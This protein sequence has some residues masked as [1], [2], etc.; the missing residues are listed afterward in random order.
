MRFQNVAIASVAYV[1]PTTVVRT[2]DLEAQLAPLYGRLGMRPGW[3]ETVTGI[4]ERRFW[5]PGV[6]PSQVAALAGRKALQSA[7][8]ATSQLGA[9][10]YTGVC[11]DYLEPSTAALTHGE[12]GLPPT[13]LNFDV[14][15][16]CLG[17]LSGMTLLASLIEGRRIEAGL[18]VA[19]ESSRDVVQATMGRLTVP[20]AGMTAFKDN[21]ATLTLGSAAVA[22][23]L[24][25][26]DRARTSHRF[27]GGVT[28][29]ATEHRGLCIGTEEKMV[30]DAPKLLAEG[31]ALAGRTWRAAEQTMGWDPLGFAEYATHQVGAANYNAVLS[32]LGLPKERA[33]KVYPSLGNCGAGAAPMAL[34]MAVEQRRVRPGQTAVLMGI[35]SGLNCSIMGVR[36]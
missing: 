14:G 22:M 13:A 26:A 30:T 33:L 31:V 36:W 32:S 28:H 9:L 15:N 35:G 16:A 18:V 3:L 5:A 11:R 20:G 25:H 27:L 21:L 29:A 1:L 4:R 8:M 23:V 17:F 6:K 19:G 24:T 2:R 7:G 10:A 34:A 12:L